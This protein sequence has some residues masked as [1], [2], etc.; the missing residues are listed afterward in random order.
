M[1]TIT[2]EQVKAIAD[3]LGRIAKENAKG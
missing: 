3:A 1:R 2:D